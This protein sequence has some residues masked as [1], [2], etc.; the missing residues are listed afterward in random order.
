[1][2]ISAADWAANS[3]PWE[4]RSGGGPGALEL[5][6]MMASAAH[7]QGYVGEVFGALKGDRIRAMHA[8]FQNFSYVLNKNVAAQLYEAQTDAAGAFLRDHRCVRP[9]WCPGW[10]SGRAGA[11]A[12]PARTNRA[13]NNINSEVAAFTAPNVNA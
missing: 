7:E 1:M 8:F 10:F 3:C 2:A 9:A 6:D 11:A 5:L 12:G 13:S 4:P